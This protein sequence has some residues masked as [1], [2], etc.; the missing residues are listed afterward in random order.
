MPG[1]FLGCVVKC[2]NQ[3]I[4]RGTGHFHQLQNSAVSRRPKAPASAD[5]SLASYV[6]VAK[7]PH[8]AQVCRWDLAAVSIRLEG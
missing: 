2:H 3:P 1:D 4:V 5:G 6:K 7:G 8:D